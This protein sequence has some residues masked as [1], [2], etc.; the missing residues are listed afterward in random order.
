MLRMSALSCLYVSRRKDETVLKA[1]TKE[2][3]GTRV[4]YGYRR[5]R[6]MLRREGH[7]DNA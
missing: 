4:Y 2:I 7:M 5:V 6:V 1:H 3:T